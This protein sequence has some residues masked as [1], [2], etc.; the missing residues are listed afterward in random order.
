LQP[1]AAILADMSR[2]LAHRAGDGVEVS[3]LWDDA[4]NRLTVSVVD[5]RTGDLFQLAAPAE[6]ALDVFHHP[7]AYAAF[8]GVPYLT[9]L[10]PV[11]AEALAA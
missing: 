3:L 7:Y 10:P 9:P 8:Q 5:S 2:E 11:A 4:D 1:A 6:N